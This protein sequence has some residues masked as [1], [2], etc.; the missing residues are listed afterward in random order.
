M[1]QST[2]DVTIPRWLAIVAL[3]NTA[4]SITIKEVLTLVRFL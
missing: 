4:I 1:K 2:E 3:I